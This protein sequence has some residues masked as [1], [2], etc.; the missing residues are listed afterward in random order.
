M[1]RLQSVQRRSNSK[2]MSLVFW[3]AHGIIIDYLEKRKTINSDYY[4]MFAGKKF[5][6]DE[7]VIVETEV[8]FVAKDKLYYKNG[9]ENCM[10]AIIGWRAQDNSFHS[11][12]T[13]LG[14]NEAISV[15][16]IHTLVG[17]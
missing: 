8:Y 3:D 7:K 15:D 16:I 10:T 12:E 4:R 14:S 1:N 13:S 9:I 17:F 6:A 5:S 11:A 2:A